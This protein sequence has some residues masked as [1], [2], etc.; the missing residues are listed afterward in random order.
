MNPD[1]YQHF[2][3]GEE[4]VE[5]YSRN[6]SRPQ[7]NR[8]AEIESISLPG[9]NI[10]SDC[11]ILLEDG[12]LETF[13]EYNAELFGIGS[14]T[15]IEGIRAL[16][17]ERMTDISDREMDEKQSL[18]LYLI[19]WG[20]RD[21][22]EIIKALKTFKTKRTYKRKQ[23][24][25][26]RSFEDLTD[27]VKE[28]LRAQYEQELPE[29]NERRKHKVKFKG[30]DIIEDTDL[31]IRFD[32]EAKASRYRQFRFREQEDWKDEL[33]GQMETETIKYWPL[34]TEYLYIDYGRKEY[35][36][37]ISRSEENLTRIAIETLFEDADFGEDVEFADPT[38]FEDSTPQDFV[39]SRIEDQK[40]AL[41]DTDLLDDGKKEQ[42]ANILDDLDSV[43]QTA[44][45]LENVNVEGNPTRIEIETDD[46]ISDFLGPHNLEE[47]L[48]EF[49]QKSQQ[50]EY[51][52]RLGDREIHVSG[53]K[54]SIMGS[55]SK[56]EEQVIT[57]LLRKDGASV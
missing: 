54:I 38:D 18:I 17:T 50:R 32:A 35:D 2:R 31:M 48:E 41:E 40:E 55:I 37:D 8:L 24:S 15:I 25:G 3:D 56:D 14:S 7:V 49:N 10:P 47:R 51:T 43:E 33:N 13:H 30:V 36:Y 1:I 6:L 26:E 53:S 9:T 46:P 22:L 12:A 52:L 27:D 20:W 57:S 16:E 29:I 21:K 44:I 4:I 19:D 45:V 5:Y 23:I 39:A 28:E 11:E 42:Y 34:T